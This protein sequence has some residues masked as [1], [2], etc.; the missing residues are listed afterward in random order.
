MKI[1]K[2]LLPFFLLLI[3]APG[4]A[5]TAS[6]TKTATPSVVIVTTGGVGLSTFFTSYSDFPSGT[7]FKPKSLLGIDWQTTSYPNNPNE[8]VELC[9][10]LPYTANPVRCDRIT[11]N[12]SGTDIGFNQ[13]TFGLGVEVMIRHSTNGGPQPAYPAGRDTVTFRY[14][15]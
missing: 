2:M 9:Y 7:A 5:V 10:F 13:Q 14:S 3:S 1:I 8:L 4:F 12:S 11:R 15:Y 6:I